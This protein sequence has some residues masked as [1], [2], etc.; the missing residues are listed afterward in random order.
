MLTDPSAYAH[1]GRH[2][3][4]LDWLLYFVSRLI[5]ESAADER[6]HLRVACQKRLRLAADDKGRAEDALAM[7]VHLLACLNVGVSFQAEDVEALLGR[8]AA[9]GR[10]PDGRAYR[11]GKTGVYIINDGLTTALA[12]QALERI[13]A[14]REN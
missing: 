13:A 1:G 4:T 12:V 9:D 3:P 10:W 14:Q 11:Y 2:Y 7:A 5:V 8:Q 6:Q